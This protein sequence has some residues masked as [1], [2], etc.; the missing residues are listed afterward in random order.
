[1]A[2]RRYVAGLGIVPVGPHLVTPS[3]RNRCRSCGATLGKCAHCGGELEVYGADTVHVERQ[4]GDL[5]HG[6]PRFVTDYWHRACR[7]KVA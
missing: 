3:A 4:V 6:A 1:M 7:E 2:L 5:M